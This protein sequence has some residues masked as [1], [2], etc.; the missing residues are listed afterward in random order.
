MELHIHQEEDR[1]SQGK[2]NTQNSTQSTN[3]PKPKNN[4]AH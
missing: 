1:K 2:Q 3:S 4:T